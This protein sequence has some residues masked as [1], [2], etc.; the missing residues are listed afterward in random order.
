[1]KLVHKTALVGGM[2]ALLLAG[3]ES[4]ALHNSAPS[5][6]VEA[7]RHGILVNESATVLIKSENT[8]GEHA[9]VDWSTTMGKITPIKD[10][11]LDFRSDKPTAIFTSDRPG[12]A[13][14][15]AKVTLE[16]GKILSDSVKITVNPTR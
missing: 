2:L 7:T 6:S 5:M 8:L 9:R 14:V 4:M 1:M 3:C 11:M 13:V 16:N 12:E 15:T 10:G